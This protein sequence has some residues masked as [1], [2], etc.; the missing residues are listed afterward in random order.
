MRTRSSSEYYTK[1]QP[2]K[3]TL[4]IAG[5]L[6]GASTSAGS[7]SIDYNK[8]REEAKT[9]IRLLP[10]YGNVPKTAE[11][12]DADEE[13]INESVKQDGSREKASQNLVTFGFDY[14]YKG[15]LRRAMYRF[16]QAWL[17]NPKNEDSFWGFG[18]VYFVFGDFDAAFT[19][20]SEGLLLNPKSSNILTDKATLFL[21]QG[22]LN[23]A[24][25]LFRK[26]YDID[27]KNQNTLI[28]YSACFFYQK[29]CANARKFYNECVKLGGK[30][31]TK[32]YSEALA[33]QCGK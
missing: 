19:Q 12:K 18:A 23:D 4:L 3:F 17:L 29:D 10:K 1:L 16:N 21:T 15:D 26:S 28:K 30:P 33:A 14:L 27:P 22:K 2:V 6:I 32:E 7:Q 13:L 20:Y 24:M 31:I 9:N 11:Q 5:A 8:W 25:Q